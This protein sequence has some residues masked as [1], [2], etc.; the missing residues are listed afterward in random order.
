MFGIDHAKTLAIVQPAAWTVRKAEKRAKL[1]QY[2][3]RV[4][5]LCEGDEEG[6]IDAAIEK[7]RTFFESLEVPTRLS[8]YGV[9]AERIDDLVRALETRGMTALGEKRGVTLEVSRRILETAL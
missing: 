9:T 6:R 7:T 3:E 1:L 8:A 4:W 5:D 2:A